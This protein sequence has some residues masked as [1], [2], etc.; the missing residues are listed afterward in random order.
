VNLDLD[1]EGLDSEGEALLA[2]LREPP[3]DL[4]EW[5][6][7]LE[8]WGDEACVVAAIAAGRLLREHRVQGE[9]VPQLEAL[10]ASEL[11]IRHPSRGVERVA[12]EAWA[13]D[14]GW[15][16]SV[17]WSEIAAEVA[18]RAH[19]DCGAELTWARLCEALRDWA[20]RRHGPEEEESSP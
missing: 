11:L 10:A 15:G 3:A 14:S 2:A 13:Q 8:A 17:E 4:R 1:S 18:W 16:L 20:V 12:R 6:L 7:A 5:L 9:E 19:H